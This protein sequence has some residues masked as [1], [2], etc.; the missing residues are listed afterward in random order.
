MTCERSTT[1]ATAELAVV[2]R[3]PAPSM[4]AEINGAAVRPAGG[5]SGHARQL[6]YKNR[7]RNAARFGARTTTPATAAQADNESKERGSK[8]P[9]SVC[10]HGYASFPL[11]A[12]NGDSPPAHQLA[13]GAPLDFCLDTKYSHRK[14]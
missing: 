9:F 7:L 10:I 13:G 8:N 3:A 11:G 14:R 12:K 4:A 6:R 1:V 2:V 5:N